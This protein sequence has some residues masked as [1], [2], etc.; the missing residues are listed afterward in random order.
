MA[1]SHRVD[2]EL[3][4]VY[5]QDKVLAGHSSSGVGVDL[6]VVEFELDL[7]I[8]LLIGYAGLQAECLVRRAFGVPLKSVRDP[9]A[10]L[11]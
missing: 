9:L 8:R 5:R 11:H 2:G 10:L 7:R 3:E 6:Y 4:G 1:N